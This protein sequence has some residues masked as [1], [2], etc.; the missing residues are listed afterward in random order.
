MFFDESKFPSNAWPESFEKHHTTWPYHS[1]VFP[2]R[3]LRYNRGAEV[4]LKQYP[5]KSFFGTSR[6]E[7]DAHFYGRIH[8]VPPQGGIPGFQRIT[9]LKFFLVGGEYD[10]GSVWAYEGCVLPGN[11][12]IVGRW[13]WI[14]D[15]DIGEKDIASGPFILWNVD[16][17][18]A[19]PPID[20]EESI[21]F[22][23]KLRDVGVGV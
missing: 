9:F 8:A 5:L 1:S 23:R 16:E 7:R 21:E 20:K 18:C 3:S 14:T 15:E 19:D 6:G 13:W 11:R 12:V 2:T 17:S 10:T 22:L 4:E